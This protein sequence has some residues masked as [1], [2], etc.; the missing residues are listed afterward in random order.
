MAQRNNK[1]TTF[2]PVVAPKLYP[3]STETANIPVWQSDGSVKFMDE[4]GVK[5][6]IDNGF[7]EMP[8]DPPS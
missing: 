3:E 7:I 4:E 8:T 1:K 6:M 2:T 5:W